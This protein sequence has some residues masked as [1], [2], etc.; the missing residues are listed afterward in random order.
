VQESL[1]EGCDLAMDYGTSRYI[2]DWQM[3]STIIELPSWRVLRW[4]GLFEQQAQ[5][6]ERQFGVALPARPTSGSWTLV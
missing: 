5:I 3:G 4:G 6:I 2:N 1:R